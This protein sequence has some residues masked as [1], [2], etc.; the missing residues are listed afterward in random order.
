MQDKRKK[1]AAGP[2]KIKEKNKFRDSCVTSD[3]GRIT[4]RARR[5]AELR[6]PSGSYAPAYLSNSALIR[7]D[8]FHG[9]FNSTD[10]EK[11]LNGPTVRYPPVGSIAD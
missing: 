5:W 3:G 4:I 11:G 6:R 2:I 7:P 10:S 8:V 1:E 9:A